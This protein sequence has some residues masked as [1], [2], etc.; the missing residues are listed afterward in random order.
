MHQPSTEVPVDFS[1]SATPAEE[2]GL[3]SSVLPEIYSYR[4]D[5]GIRVIIQSGGLKS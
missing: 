3:S 1:V 5:A 4:E 2:A